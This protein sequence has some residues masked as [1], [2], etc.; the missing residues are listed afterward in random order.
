M[1]NLIKFFLV[2]SLVVN[3]FAGNKLIDPEIEKKVDDLLSKMTLEEKIGQM[4]QYSNS[5]DVTGPIPTS[6]ANLNKYNQIKSG[7]VGSMLNVVGTKATRKMQEL[8]VENSRLGIPLIFGLDVIHGYKTIFPIP[9]GEAASWDMVAIEKSARISAIEA[10]ASGIHWTFGPMVDIC[11]DPRWGRIMEGAGEDPYL[12]SQVATA[13][14]NGFQGDNLK[15]NNTIA[16]CAKHYAGYGFGQAGRD[17]NTVDIS[18]KTL[19]DIVLPPFKACAEAGVATYMNSFNELFGLPATGSELLL[20]Q[21]LKGEWDFQGFVVSDWGSIGEMMEHGVAKDNYDAANLAVHAGSDMDMQSSAYI[22]NL[23]KLVKDGK[24]DGTLIDD[25]VRRILRIKFQLGLFDDPYLYCNEVRGETLLKHPDHIQAARDVARKSI[26]LL[27]NKK[28]I[29]PLKKDISSIAVIGPLADEKDAPIGNWRA[30][31]EKKSAVSLLEGVK[32]GVSS[33]TKIY[34]AQGC[35]L[36]ES[37]KFSFDSVPVINQT[38][39]KSFEDA[40]EIAKKAEVVLLAV[41]EDAFQSGEASSRANINLP[42]LQHELIRK[43]YEVNQNIVLILMNG[44]PLTISWEA[45]NLPAILETWFLGSESGNAIS[46][47]IFGDYNPSGKLPVTFPRVL[48]QV[49]IYYNHKNTGRPAKE[50]VKFTSKYIDVDWTPLYPFGYGLSYTEF[51][52]LRLKIESEKIS[53]DGYL[54]VSVKVKNKGKVAGTEIVQLYIRDL[55]G[56][57]TRPV[58]ELK[59]FRKVHLEPGKSKKVEF[60]ISVSQLAFYGNNNEFIVEPGEFEVLV[61]GNSE[62]VLKTGFEVVE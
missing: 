17:Y 27:K 14:V 48:G 11:R 21:I 10:S 29:L 38:D 54:N 41:G 4:N 58:K 44:R 3:L 20:R 33:E 57:V 46:D 32:N 24:V 31:G 60:K 22:D 18:M 34:Y 36:V 59:G 45:E 9:L 51:D 12:G 55:V 50:N 30:Q 62:D 52:Y 35:K 5:F 43:I 37:N 23:E 61:G 15:E 25:A 49:P 40:I 6:T 7:K 42:G 19:R 13:R 1:K 2:C 28:D 26:V 56:S 53:R 8:A 39:R 47:V 16:A